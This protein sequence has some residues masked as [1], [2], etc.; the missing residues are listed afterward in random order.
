MFEFTKFISQNSNIICSCGR[1]RLPMH[2]PSCG[3]ISFIGKVSLNRT[4]DI[5]ISSENGT[6]ELKRMI[7]S[8]FKCRKCGCNYT[9]NV[10]AFHCEAPRKKSELEV[11]EETLTPMKKNDFFPQDPN[12]TLSDIEEMGRQRQKGEITMAEFLEKLCPSMKGVK[13]QR[14]EEVISE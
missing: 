6:M 10:V 12:L 4:I 1:D 13:V 8:G 2:C 7:V 3:S 14:K 9:E 5:P 11:F